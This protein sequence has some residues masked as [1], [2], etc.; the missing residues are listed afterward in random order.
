MRFC[1]M[2]RLIKQSAYVR[3]LTGSTNLLAFFQFFQVFHDSLFVIGGQANLT[4]D[5]GWT[6][7]S[8]S[9]KYTLLLSPQARDDALAM[10]GV[11]AL[12]L[13]RGPV[14]KANTADILHLGGL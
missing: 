3:F 6:Q 12:E 1:F 14:V 7:L 8:L 10:E 9:A 13:E 11:G 4:V 2:H 5:F